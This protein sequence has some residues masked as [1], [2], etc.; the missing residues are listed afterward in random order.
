MGGS[1]AGALKGRCRAVTGV[2]A[3]AEAARIALARGLIDETAELMNA[4]QSADIVVLA[5][6][7]RMRHGAHTKD[8]ALVSSRE[9]CLSIWGAR[10]RRFWTSWQRRRSMSR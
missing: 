1:L 10:R 6:P 8:F 5:T 3:R 4:V 2:D 9:P 7:V